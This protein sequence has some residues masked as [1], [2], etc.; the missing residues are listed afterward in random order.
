MSALKNKK[1]FQPNPL[2]LKKNLDKFG[3]I[4]P[5]VAAKLSFVNFQHTSFCYT[6]KE[7]INLKINQTYLHSN[8]STK[9]EAEKWFKSLK[10]ENTPVLYVYGVGLGYYYEAAKNWLEEDASR[11]LVFLENDLAV[12]YRLLQT[13]MGTKIL[14]DKQVQL[15][16]FENIDQDT[17]MIQWLTWYFV[18]NSLE[19]STLDSYQKTH[20]ETLASIK[21][22]IGHDSVIKNSLVSEYLRHGATFYHNF[23]SNMLHLSSSYLGDALTGK[24]KGVPAIICGAG[25]SLNKNID[26]LKSLNNQALLFAGGSS[27]NALTSKGIFPHFGAG[28]DPNPTQLSRLVSNFAFETPYFY[29]SRMFH[30]AFKT[31]HGPRL[32]V[33]GSGGFNTS[34][35]FEKKLDIKSQPVDEG[36][37]VINLCFSI[38]NMLGC[39]P[40]I[41]VG[42]DL[43]Y[44][45]MKMYAG[46]ILGDS[47]VNE[48]NITDA[49]NLDT[50]A[51][52]RKD[53]H[54]NPVYTLWK[55]I[56]ESQWIS[57]TAEDFKKEKGKHEVPFI[58]ATEGGIG[59]ANIPNMTLKEATEKFL[60]KH[61]DLR[62]RVHAEMMN[63][64][65]N[66][67]S[68]QK[69]LDLIIELRDSLINCISHCT[70]LIDEVKKVQEK[71]EKGK[72]TTKNLQ[73]GLAALAETELSEE[74]AFEYVL[75][76]FHNMIA[77]VLERERHCIRYDKKLPTEREKNI[78]RLEVNKKKFVFLRETAKTNIKVMK[79][80]LENFSKKH[81]E[82]NLQDLLNE[83]KWILK[84][85][86]KQ[87]G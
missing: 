82:H 85:E 80:S 41:F 25:P 67:V 8:Y 59:F 68:Q 78:Q 53:I 70:I 77:K 21:R 13:D 4:L 7:E 1:E 44:T 43:A 52:P 75:E 58:N 2:V 26:Q 83:D 12:I 81:P 32:Y 69:V 24:F 46:G 38:A 35:W 11:C 14:D 66:Q 42:M 49:S 40:I 55:W 63:V 31:I 57:E 20:P 16:Y 71:L 3:Q 64:T 65:L 72:N 6:R 74:P 47:T 10:L 19:I 17:V 79:D 9:A 15:H 62:S 36:H 56:A 22:R 23:Y 60:Q 87:N 29:R 76:I 51:F 84:E 86:D 50:S 73:T 34:E 30:S 18:L 37:N 28:I 54:G 48:T 27:M 61:Q 45:D 39:S 5:N 33:T